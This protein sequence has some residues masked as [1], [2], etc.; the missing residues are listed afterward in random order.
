ML[1]EVDFNSMSWHTLFLVGGGNVLGKAIESS[2]LLEYLST[3]IIAILPLDQ[4]WFA[5]L[6]S[7]SLTY[8]FTHSYLL[9]HSL[10]HSLTYSLLRSRFAL[11]IILFFCGVIATF[12]SHTVASIILLPVLTHSLT[13]LLLLTYLLTRSLTYLLTH[14]LGN[15]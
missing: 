7:H 5:H 14:S 9:T 11:L 13:Y 4:P 6:L 10:T 1:T 8:S 2:G 12:V 3:G 15:F